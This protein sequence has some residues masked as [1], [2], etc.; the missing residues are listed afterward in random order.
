[1]N[2][3]IQGND[4][5]I[6]TLEQYYYHEID[7]NNKIPHTKFVVT[8]KDFKVIAYDSNKV[9]FQGKKASE[10][11]AVWQQ[12]ASIMI[13]EELIAS[14]LTNVVLHESIG[15]DEVGTGDFF[16]PVVVCACYINENIVNQIAQYNITDSKM[17][18]DD[19]ICDVANKIEKYVPH[20]IY[21]LD[22]KTYNK[23]HQTNNLNQIKAKMHNYVLAKLI[24]KIN[25]KPMIIV[26]QFCSEKNYYNY[27]KDT[28]NTVI[29][30]INFETKAESKYLA[31]AL[32]SMFAR[33]A[34]LE[35]ID[36][37]SH[38]LNINII[39][40]ASNLVDELGVKIVNHYGLEILDEIAKTHF[41]NTAKIKEKLKQ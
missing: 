22:N 15:S 9:M 41:K 25:K 18:S 37:L 23:V 13:E 28:P 8:N 10:E 6:K 27:L 19:Y 35:E 7:Q 30:G 3:V 26:D 4:K 29:D 24:K 39:K 12:Q 38:R 14:N 32:A 1:M 33:N 2:I 5:L 34:F 21:I 40:G 16:G 31:V 20:V 17:L 36:K 11:A